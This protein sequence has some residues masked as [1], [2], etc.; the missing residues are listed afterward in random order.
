MIPVQR[1]WD[2]LAPRLAREPRLALDFESD[3]FHHYKERLSLVQIAAPGQ[4]WILDP[5]AVKDVS[6]LGAILANPG[7][8]KVLHGSDYDVR[9]LDRAWGFRIKG[10]RDTATATQ[11]L[12]PEL[13]GLGRAIETYL[14]IKLP[15]LVRL[16]RSDWSRRPIPADALEYAVL[17]VAHSLAL[18]DLLMAKLKEL[19]RDG[20]LAEEC[21]LMESI[22]YEPPP[23]PEEACFG[24]KGAFDLEPRAL[25][26]FR[27]LWMVRE[28]SAEQVDRPPFKVISAEALLAI[29]RDPDVDGDKIPNA[30][31]RWLDAMRGEIIAAVQRGR[32]A[33]PII[34]PSRL[35]R[36]PSPWTPEGRTRWQ[37]LHA[38]RVAKA[39]E[40]GIA[41]S[42]LW[43]TRSLEALCIDPERLEPEL[44]GQSEFSVRRWQR[45]LLA[46]PLRAAWGTAL[47]SGT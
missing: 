20:W 31:W 46:G 2:A 30:N 37:V 22:R 39:A 47:S 34:H 6:A 19:G 25:A 16:Q 9:T 26:I 45:E 7:I 40:L 32:A 43:P 17:D 10:L 41:P 42:T 8:V 24:S 18:D 13:M 1:D 12:H 14:G 23:P 38:V 3:G 5:L 15:K 27:E 21:A 36:R 11:L 35:K 28:R 44:S 33:E 4:A 29:A